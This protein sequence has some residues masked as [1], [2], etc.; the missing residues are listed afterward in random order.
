M[1]STETKAFEN[2]LKEF[3]ENPTAEKRAE[4]LNLTAKS[5]S[6]D[7]HLAVEDG[8]LQKNA[9][10]SIAIANIQQQYL[11]IKYLVEKLTAPPLLHGIC[12]GHNNGTAQVVP[13]GGGRKIETTILPELPSTGLHIG[14]DVLLTSD[15]TCILKSLGSYTGGFVADLDEVLPDG[16]YILIADGNS[17]IIAHPSESLRGVEL[18]PGAKIRHDSGIAFEVIEQKEISSSVEDLKEVRFSDIGGLEEQIALIKREFILPILYPERFKAPNGVT[19]IGPPGNGKTTL[20]IATIFEAL[21]VYAL[22][23]GI[24]GIDYRRHFILVRGFELGS[25]WYSQ[26]ERAVKGLFERAKEISESTG[27]LPTLIFLDEPEGFLATRGSNISSGGVEDRV[28]N[29]FCAMMDG[30]VK[31]DGKISVMASTNRPDMI[32][33]AVMRAGRLGDQIIE[34]P[35]PKRKAA[36]DIFKIH[37]NKEVDQMIKENIIASE[38]K[39]AVAELA[40]A[41]VSRIYCQNDTENTLAKI[42]FSDGSRQPLRRHQL[43]SGAM[44]KQIVRNSLSRVK[45]KGVDLGNSLESMEKLKELFTNQTKLN[46]LPVVKELNSGDFLYAVDEAF[47]SLITKVITRDNIRHYVTLPQDSVVVAVEPV[48]SQVS[49]NKYIRQ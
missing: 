31:L 41:A 9:A 19:L 49:S 17:P 25:M 29:M 6:L 46:E 1:S 7:Y 28:V 45:S 15:S 37:L 2:L 24:D 47:N 8:L 40:E 44:A 42:I 34:I 32:D 21:D 13:M 18:K 27:G 5:S 12:T 48:P 20:G 3:E 43:F 22:K 23:Y 16:R 26:S 38:C 33:P 10:K 30:L 35:P 36:L 14:D 4:I 39:S 11:E